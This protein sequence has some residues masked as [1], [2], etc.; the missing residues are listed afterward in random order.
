[1]ELEQTLAALDFVIARERML[2]Q[3]LAG[4]A[5]P[6][7]LPGTLWLSTGATFQNG[8]FGEVHFEISGP[9]GSHPYT[10]ASGTSQA[11]IIEAIN[12]HQSPLGVSAGQEPL[13]AARVRLTTINPGILQFVCV[14][15]GSRT[16]GL[17]FDSPVATDGHLQLCDAGS[18]GVTGDLNC[19]QN[20]NATDAAL[21]LAAW[22][23][24][25]AVVDLD[26]SGTVD[27]ADLSIVLGAWT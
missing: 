11:N 21:V 22:G 25:S 14:R 17:I 6:G 26:G 16:A 12:D 18:T 24:S 27:M 8:G 23:T 20:V 2:L 10:F 3:D 13:N 4:P 7:A 5:D 19:D 9:F 1:M 15:H